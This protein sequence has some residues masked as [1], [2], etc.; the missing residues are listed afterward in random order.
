MKW[1]DEIRMTNVARRRARSAAPYLGNANARK[2]ILVGRAVPCTPSHFI[3]HSSFVLR[4][5]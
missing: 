5:F 1:N 3:R 2:A 4:H